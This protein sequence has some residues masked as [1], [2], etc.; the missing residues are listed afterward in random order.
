MVRKR[1]AESYLG[2]HQVKHFGSGVFRKR[3]DQEGD[4]TELD[5]AIEQAAKQRSDAQ[6]WARGLRQQEERVEAFRKANVPKPLL[7]KEESLLRTY[8]QMARV[9]ERK[10]REGR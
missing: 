6:Q 3:I 5:S 1:K 8:R 2:G 4:G 9:S 10:L 7:E